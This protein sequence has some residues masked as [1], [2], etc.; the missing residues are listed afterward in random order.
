[1]HFQLRYLVA[2]LCAL[3]AGS[4][5]CAEITAL[6]AGSESFEPPPEY[7]LWW[8][9]TESC[10]EKQG[11][12]A[13]VQWYIVPN[14]TVLPG[15]EGEF[16]GEWFP[17]RNRV[18][19][20]SADQHDGELVRHEMLH[21]LLQEAGHPRS[22]F[23]ERCAGIVV[24]ANRCM[25]DAGAAPTPPAGS[26]LVPASGLEIDIQLQPSPTRANEFDGHFELIVTARNP[27][28]H[29]VVVQLPSY[30]DGNLGVS[31]AYLVGSDSAHLSGTFSLAYDLEATFFQAGETKRQAFD[32]RMGAPFDGNYAPG[33]YVAYGVFGD[34]RSSLRTIALS[35]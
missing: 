23:L 30:G 13:D 5:A 14:T 16:S 26:P 25:H 2:A 17:Q 3:L 34:H 15:T 28:N 19:L 31:F 9:M 27:A 18:V 29:A 10:S 4:V 33:S 12:L 35:Q 20:T 21:A 11:A 24:C 6:P 8:S 32:L 7:E 1:V 22:Q